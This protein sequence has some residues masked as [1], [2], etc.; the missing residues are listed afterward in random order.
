MVPAILDEQGREIEGPG[1]GY[2][3]SKLYDFEI[4]KNLINQSDVPI[5]KFSFLSCMLILGK[6]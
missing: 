6:V 1:E 4:V 5:T 2:L 3:V